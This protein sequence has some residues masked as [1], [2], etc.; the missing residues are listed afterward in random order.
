MKQITA[1]VNYSSTKSTGSSVLEF[2]KTAFRKAW[3]D[4]CLNENAISPEVYDA[5]IR[6]L[7][8]QEVYEGVG[9]TIPRQAGAGGLR[10]WNEAAAFVGEDG[11]VWQIRLDVPRVKDGKILKY[12]SLKN[13]G[14]RLYFPIVPLESRKLMSVLWG[15]NVPLTGSFWVWFCTSQEAKKLPLLPTEGGTKALSLISRGFPSLSLYGCSS[16]WERRESK[17][18][19][20]QLLPLLREA[21]RGRLVVF[22]FDSDV[23]PNAVLAVRSSI[24]LI[25]TALYRHLSPE[26]KVMTWDAAQG[27]GI[28]DLI[29]QSGVLP[30]FRA[31]KNAVDFCE[32]KSSSTKEWARRTYTQYSALAV[33]DIV[34]N[35]DRV[36]DCGFRLPNLGEA[37]L[38]CAS[39][40]AGKTYAFGVAIKALRRQYPDLIVDAIGHR[41]NLLIQTSKRLDLNH[42]H[43]LIAGKH[44]ELQVVNADSLAYCADSLWRRFD[45]LMDFMAS[46]RKVLLILDEVDAL[47][48]HI[49]L[50]ETIKTAARI[51][52]I[53]KFSILLS[54][55]GL[56]GGW[57]AGG[58][59]RLTELAA[60][61]LRSLS[62]GALKVTVARNVRKS[63]PW[64]VR[65]STGYRINSDGREIEVSAKQAAM[66]EVTERLGAG[67][68]VALL[69]T[70]QQAAEEFEKDFSKNYKVWRLDSK[71]SAEAE[72]KDA[73]KDMGRAIKNSP[74]QLIVL[75]PTLESGVSIDGAGLVD[76]IVL[77]ASCLDPSTSYQLLGRFRDPSIPR[78]ICAAEIGFSPKIKGSYDPAV[79][80]QSWR[81]KTQKIMEAHDVYAEVDSVLSAAHD[82]ASKYVTREA[83]GISGLRENLIEKLELEGHHIE[84][85][86]V[87]I[88]SSVGDRI[89]A[90][91][92]DVENQT[93]DDWMAADDSELSADQA[94]DRMK[95]S[96]LRYDE[97]VVCKKAIER[98]KYGSLVD[99]ASWVEEYCNARKG[100][101]RKSA[102]RSAAEYLHD[103][104]AAA[105][106]GMKVKSQLKSTGTVWGVDMEVRAEVM[107]TLKKL[108]L[109]L[110]LPIAD[111]EIE[112]H[113]EHPS[114]RTVFRSA[115]L[116][117]DE[118]SDVLGLYVTPSSSPMAFVAD[119]LKKHLGFKFEMRKV[120]IP[121][122]EE[123]LI[124]LIGH[125]NPHRYLYED[126]RAQLINEEEEGQQPIPPK[127]GRGRP[128][129]SE[130]AKGRTKRV[131]AYRLVSCPHHA[132][133]VE[134][135]KADHDRAVEKFADTP[136]PIAQIQ[137]GRSINWDGELWTVL[138]VRGDSVWLYE[139]RSP[140]PLH[141]CLKTTME[142]VLLGLNKP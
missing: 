4:R 116:L 84:R 42:I 25:G 130:A 43:D 50:S 99:E 14:A 36:S 125:E 63:Q 77:Y 107:E 106:D 122:N 72:N 10:P 17:Y 22:A 102:V 16:A 55:I 133:M 20:R 15:V 127:K 100:R 19:R 38:Y 110:L 27:K 23:K 46:G 97:R 82:I 62:S 104:M 126:F 24:A 47:L 66:Q 67:Q 70:S 89:K 117:P 54:R 121:C 64:E 32:W 65:L 91:K 9:W 90:A 41:N 101:A 93:F 142:Y 83:A 108:N 103:G 58:E 40:G 39:L 12:E 138:S 86:S 131:R 75:S 52:L 44:T 111:T 18:D 134:A 95:D 129:K 80:L 105:S 60:D 33:A 57:V 139:G 118:V 56:G 45:A 87:E 85:S 26:V 8:G 30:F 31:F 35:A 5:N 21:A 34:G 49:L 141:L 51:R 140:V 61:S 113:A 68:R 109:H 123:S 135:I 37:L 78:V 59:A 28:D 96:S 88:D 136:D 69:A 74:A 11:K 137:P 112:I 92:E 73:F 29:S 48:K 115:L 81:D 6:F 13:G 98:E 114:V 3:R 124:E 7:E 94:R 1:S 128:P 79:V 2:P 132:D 71:T 76:A 119:L 120:T 53:R